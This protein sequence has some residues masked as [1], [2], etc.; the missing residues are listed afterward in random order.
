MVQILSLLISALAAAQPICPASQILKKASDTSDY[1][2]LSSS[3]LSAAAQSTATSYY[4]GQEKYIYRSNSTGK[5]YVFIGIG[6]HC[7]IWMDKDVQSQLRCSSG[8]TSSIAK[9][10]AGVYDGQPYRILNTLAGGNIPYE[11]NSGKISILLETFCSASGMYMY[12]TGITAIHINTTTASAYVSGEMSKRNGL[13]VHEGQHAL[14]WLK[15]RFSNTGR[16]MWLN[17]GLAVTAMDYLWGGIDSSGWLNGIAGS[18][19][20]QAA[21]P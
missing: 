7:Y 2:V 6:E 3:A 11:D 21:L 14:L 16:Y 13:L 1:N 8:K 20:I 12:D 17:E 5:T 9:D 19:A 18:T 15:T 4:I 10:M